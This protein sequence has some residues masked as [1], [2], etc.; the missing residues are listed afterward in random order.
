[1]K[2]SQVDT[3]SS[4]QPHELRATNVTPS[5]DRPTGQTAL[6]LWCI[7]VPRYYR[8]VAPE[9][10]HLMLKRGKPQEAVGELCVL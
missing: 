4:I 8:L 5:T 2:D 9:G 1:M 6:V 3:V 7:V 10:T